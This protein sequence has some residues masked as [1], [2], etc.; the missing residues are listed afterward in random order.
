MVHTLLRA[1]KPP[2][3]QDVRVHDLRN[4][5]GMRLRKA[6]VLELLDALNLINDESSRTNTIL[7]MLFREKSE[8]TDSDRLYYLL[9]VT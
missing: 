6:G 5:A 9:T 3:L 4:T 7:E 1:R 8:S 2:L